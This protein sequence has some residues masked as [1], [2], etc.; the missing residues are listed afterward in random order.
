VP[1][2][3]IGHAGNV[4]WMMLGEAYRL[5]LAVPQLVLPL[6]KAM[7]NLPRLPPAIGDLGMRL[8]QCAGS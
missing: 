5:K 8:M 4:R 1:R 6:G 2:T 3:R 7:L